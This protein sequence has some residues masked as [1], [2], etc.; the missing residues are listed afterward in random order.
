MNSTRT[1]K[2]TS[3]SS[4]GQADV[5]SIRSGGGG[6]S[7]LLRLACAVHCGRAVL[8]VPLALLLITGAAAASEPERSYRFD[9]EAGSL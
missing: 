7:N 2:G 6:S 4:N 9:I 8:S 1:G 5:G 3:S